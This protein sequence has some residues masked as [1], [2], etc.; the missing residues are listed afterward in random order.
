M[1]QVNKKLSNGTATY[2]EANS[3]AIKI[4]EILAE[5]FQENLSSEILPNGRMYYNIAKKVIEPMMIN[6][7]DLI[8]ENSA[9]IQT[10]L[11]Q[12]V[13]LG[14]VGQKPQLN[15][16]RI[17]GI[18]QRLADEENFDDVKWILKEPVINFSQSIVDDTIQENVKFHFEAGLEP[19]IVRTA[20]AG[21]CEWCSKMVG[22]FNY[23]DEVPDD[24]YRR[25]RYCRCEVD[26]LPDDGRQQNVHS[27]RWR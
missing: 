19:K 25:H 18:V 26:Y 22:T 1:R 9:S 6:N 21:C 13:G 2:H 20:N 10:V 8:A 3:F 17:E 12:N 24:I 15:Q 5:V 16:D 4:G 23:P 7:Y 11:N 27:K 14:I